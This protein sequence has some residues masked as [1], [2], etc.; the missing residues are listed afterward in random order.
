MTIGVLARL[1]R[2]RKSVFGKEVLLFLGALRELGCKKMLR[3][4]VRIKNKALSSKKYVRVKRNEVHL[5]HS[6]CHHV[7]TKPPNK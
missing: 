4:L 5:V 3:I 6:Y 2:H 7:V 1:R